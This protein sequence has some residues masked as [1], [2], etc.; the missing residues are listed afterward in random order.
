MW[1]TDFPHPEGC[2]PHTREKMLQFMT[3][4]PE[5]E[6]TKMLGTNAIACYDL[7]AAALGELAGRVGP[8]QSLFVAEASW[9]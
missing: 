1:G 2:W 7:A 6:L 8:A 9:E 5:N 4:I 3:G